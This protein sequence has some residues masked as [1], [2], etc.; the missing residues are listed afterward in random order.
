[1]SRM[2]SASS[3]K[4][5]NRFY[6]LACSQ[7]MTSSTSLD[8]TGRHPVVDNTS[9][10]GVDLFT[11][12]DDL[13][14]LDQRK[15]SVSSGKHQFNHL[16]RDRSDA[17]HGRRTRRLS[18]YSS[19]SDVTESDSKTGR[20]C[21]R[22]SRSRMSSERS[23]KQGNRYL[24]PWTDPDTSDDGRK[25][26][27]RARRRFRNEELNIGR[28]HG[29][30]SVPKKSTDRGRKR[31]EFRQTMTSDSDSDWDRKCVVRMSSK[32]SGKGRLGITKRMR[33]KRSGKSGF[34]YYGVDDSS[35][36]RK[37]DPGNFTTDRELVMKMLKRE[38]ELRFS[39]ET[40]C[41]YDKGNGL[42]GHASV[43]PGSI[44]DKIQIQVLR[45]HKIE[46]TSANI[47]QY[48]CLN[49]LFRDDKTVRE[50]VVYMSKDRSREGDLR[51][52]DNCPDVPLLSTDLVKLKLTDLFPEDGKP[53]MVFAASRS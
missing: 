2:L 53:L 42:P 43:P 34:G 9:S 44:E 15:Y 10:A 12:K 51:M 21:R 19:D 50:L 16:S 4:R 13:S 41:L 40:Q 11:K 52:G 31:Q 8:S 45:E 23:G 26:E 30:T 49:Y 36:A 5:G 27:H 47:H 25:S 1:M 18:R 17:R 29:R 33:S 14:S 39:Q 3:G 46:P 20:S 38:N 22:R 6:G 48:R 28:N 7:S 24:K 32:H 35:K 37:D